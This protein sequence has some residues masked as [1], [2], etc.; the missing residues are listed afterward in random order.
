[1]SLI[2]RKKIAPV[3]IGAHTRIC[4]L[5]RG[6]SWTAPAPGK[7]CM[8]RRHGHLSLGKVEG[9]LAQGSME[10][11]LGTYLD[12]QGVERE[13]WIPVARFVDGR[14][15]TRRISYHPASRTGMVT[16]QLVPG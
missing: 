12:A 14:R 7:P 5:T 3:G 16:M 4:C 15:W 9:L 11:V 6:E 2:S 8:N 13:T 10:M 1:M